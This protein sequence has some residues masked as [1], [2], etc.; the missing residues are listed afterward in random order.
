MAFFI[1]VE[2]CDLKMEQ[3]VTDSLCDLSN[4]ILKTNRG[5]HVPRVAAS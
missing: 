2:N 3:T 5:Q 1:A 4:F